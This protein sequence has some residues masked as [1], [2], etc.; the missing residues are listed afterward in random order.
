MKSI[1]EGKV[2]KRAFER[3]YDTLSDYDRDVIA[4]DKEKHTELSKWFYATVAQT[5]KSRYES[6][7]YW[8]NQPETFMYSGHASA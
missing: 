3:I 4:A 7:D 6:A 1:H 8:Y 5:A 2:T